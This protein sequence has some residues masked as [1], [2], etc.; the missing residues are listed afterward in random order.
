MHA[1]VQSPNALQGSPGGSKQAKAVGRRQQK[2]TGHL[3]HTVFGQE[4]KTAHESFD[5]QQEIFLQA[6]HSR[7]RS[8]PV[9]EL[10]K[11]NMVFRVNGTDFL[12]KVRQDLGGV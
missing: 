6:L 5:G 2:P 7:D 8:A 10:D 3:K 4:R 9:V 12:A 1:R 11:F